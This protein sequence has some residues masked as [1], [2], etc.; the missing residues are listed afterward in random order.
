M[1]LRCL[2]KDMEKRFQ[3]TDDVC[4]ALEELKEES[5][6]GELGVPPPAPHRPPRRRGLLFGV[7]VAATMLAVAA[8]AWRGG[9]PRDPVTPPALVHVTSYPGRQEQPALSPDGSQIAFVWNGPNRDNYDIYLKQIGQPDALRLTIDPA[10]DAYPVWSPDGKRIA[11]RRGDDIYT[12]S[13]LGGA[14]R[15]LTSVIFRGG[16]LSTGD[17]QMSR[18]PDEKWLALASSPAIVVVPT[19]GGEPRRVTNP[20]P[21][22]IDRTPVFSRD[23]RQLAYTHCLQSGGRIYLGGVS[24]YVQIQ[25]LDAEARPA[26]APRRVGSQ[27]HSSTGLAW[28]SDGASFV[29]GRAGSDGFR[30]WQAPADGRRP[31]HWIEL[32]GT[33]TGD[34]MIVGGRLAFY[35]NLDNPDIWRHQMS[36]ESEPS[37]VSTDWDGTPQYSPDGRRIAFESNRGTLRAQIWVA[38]ADGSGPTQ[39]TER[40]WASRPQWSPDGRWIAYV[41]RDEDGFLNS[42]V[43]D[44]AGG[45]PRR[46]TLDVSPTS[47]P[48]FSRDGKWI[49][50]SSDRSARAE[51]MRVPFRGGPPEPVTTTGG[52][53]AL[54]SPDGRILFYARGDA[55]FAKALTGGSERQILPAVRSRGAAFM[56][57]EGGVYFLGPAPDGRAW[58]IQFLDL[59][60]N[61]SREL[62]KIEGT[63]WTQGPLS[64]SP[65]GKAILYV[66]SVITGSVIEIIENFR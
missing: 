24:C 57:V 1:I 32:A 53:N 66:K 21:S 42:Y 60:T 64:V 58:A 4:V 62:T 43:I 27:A 41:A 12:M 63:D 39:L 48:S 13:S 47:V 65:D 49:Y 6:S 31:G 40:P 29:L 16:W 51:V 59:K 14:E 33:R 7:A 34:P 22:A 36:G 61:A 5:D 54:E 11:F 52:T 19:E 44:A 50:F 20:E 56:P 55:V 18:S 37:I 25:P 45:K 17:G 30:L 35:R 38:N 9:E 46:V 28:S 26:G 2:R 8:L 10:L 15:K 23:G 3:H